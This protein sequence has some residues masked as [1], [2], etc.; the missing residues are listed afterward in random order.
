MEGMPL[1]REKVSL[2]GAAILLGALRA[3]PADASDLR[4]DERYNGAPAVAERRWY[5][6][7]TLIADVT[8]YGTGTALRAVA[9][10]D[11]A[12]EGTKTAISV[13]TLGAYVLV[14]PLVHGLH[15]HA[16]KAFGSAGMRIGGPLVA[17]AAGAAL[18]WVTSGESD[19]GTE[20]GATLGVLA[21]MIAV[22]IIDAAAV[23]RE[24]VYRAD[25]RPYARTTQRSLSLS[26]LAR[27]T[28][29]GGGIVGLAGLF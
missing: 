1:L 6:W 10:A 14:S 7:Q 29:G 16:G 5:G 11:G 8:I 28:P 3:S 18:G 15:G 2:L 25:P 17:G 12:S 22:T 4:G 27:A 24:D 13:A 20:D 23:A 21:G 26:P 19:K 9:D